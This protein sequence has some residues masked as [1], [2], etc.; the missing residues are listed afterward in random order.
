MLR[1]YHRRVFPSVATRASALSSALKRPFSESSSA[2][3]TPTAALCEIYLPVTILS[4]RFILS[5]DIIPLSSEFVNTCF[6]K[7]I[8]N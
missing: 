5:K 2:A 1:I 7:S 6:L 4:H 3:L 8:L